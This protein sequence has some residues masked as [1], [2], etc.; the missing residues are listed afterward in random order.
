MRSLP[1]WVEGA[2]RPSLLITWYR[3]GTTTP[4]DLTGATL[5]GF[6]RADEATRVIVG[7]LTITSAANGIFRW[8]L[9][10]ADVVDVG[11]VVVQFVATFASGQTP[12]KTFTVSW[13]FEAAL[14][15]TP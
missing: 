11:S 7:T 6:I 1:R 8:D 3:E 4:E 10:T 5:T 13:Y 9:D 14:V 2:E 15:V 12:A